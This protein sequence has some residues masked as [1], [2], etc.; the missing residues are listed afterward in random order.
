MLAKQAFGWLSHLQCPYFTFTDFLIISVNIQVV[1][2][3]ALH[4]APCHNGVSSTFSVST[5]PW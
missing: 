5:Y 1:A 3:G 2:E 4:S